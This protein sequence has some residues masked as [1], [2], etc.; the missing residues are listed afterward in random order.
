MRI[1]RLV[2]LGS[3]YLLIASFKSL[4]Q[5]GTVA[6]GGSA[7]GSSGSISY[8]LG[9]VVFTS[10]N[11]SK[12]I[13]IQGIQQGYTP[14]DLPISLLEFKATVISN[15]QVQLDWA[16]ALELNNEY[17]TVEHSK[18]GITFEDIATVKSKGSSNNQEYS[19]TDIAPFAGISYYRLKQTDINGQFT[20]SKTIAVSLVSSDNELTAYP[21]PTITTLNLQI[22]DA[23]SKKLIYSLY[24]I[25]GKFILQQL[26]TNDLTVISTANLASGI[27]IL[28]VGQ[29]N[30]TIKS[31]RV[32]KN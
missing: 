9:E 3:F 12:G 29:N 16:T 32:I 8:S 5:S 7:K 23:A 14:A 22:K 11:S 13:V 30:S 27:Y 20:Y 31:F 1:T 4:A 25:D 17:F 24:T 26:V 6:S 2:L 10:I 21:N 15:K 19:A 28:Q 18:D